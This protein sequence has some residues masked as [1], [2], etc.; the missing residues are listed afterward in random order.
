MTGKGSDRRPTL[1]PDHELAQRW[2]STFGSRDHWSDSRPA[3]W[4][5]FLGACIA[6]AWVLLYGCAHTPK[7]MIG[8]CERPPM[9]HQGYELAGCGVNVR[10]ESQVWCLYVATLNGRRCRA[11]ITTQGCKT[12]VLDDENTG[13]DPEG[14][15]TRL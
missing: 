15:A 7:P 5:L 12:W 10:D 11:I 2:D 4:T 13:C 8:A 9:V 1:I 3:W 6:L 14:K